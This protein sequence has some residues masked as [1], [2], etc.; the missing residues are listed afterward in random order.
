VQPPEQLYHYTSGSGLHGILRTNTL[1]GGN[2][3]FMNDRSEF[4]Y[5]QDLLAASLA[6]LLQRE[7][8]PILQR[9]LSEA[10][11]PAA[12]D[13]FDLYLTCFCEEAD[14]LSQWRGYG[15]QGSRYCLEV[16][17]VMLHQAHDTPT[18][19]LSV[20]YDREK[21]RSWLDLLLKTHIR[22]YEPVCADFDEKGVE[23]A[24]R[25]IVACSLTLLPRF[26]NPTF[27]EEKEWRCVRLEVA[28]H[29][30]FEELEF[31]DSGG[32]MKPYRPVLRG[33]RTGER[34]PITR[35]IAGASRSDRQSL[36]SAWLLLQ[37]FGYAGTPVVLSDVPLLPTS[38]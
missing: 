14:L 23:L 35:V 3:A 13:P 2:H 31:M 16:A 9:I 33:S 30:N 12:F 11:K 21:Q 1:L 22:T 17:S 37:R 34:L 25:C 28:V 26:K 29:E 32:V 4:Q 15:G 6:D 10:A 20:I 18:P 36:K 27:R 24:A 38:G 5:G 7:T 19:V 8:N